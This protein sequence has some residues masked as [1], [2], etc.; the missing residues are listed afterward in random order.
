MFSFK[1]ETNP[2]IISNGQPFPEEIH[3]ILVKFEV[4]PNT[5]EAKKNYWSLGENWWKQIID[6][7][8]HKFG[9]MVFDQGLHKGHVEPGY[10]EGI[11][12]ASKYFVETFDKKFGS[13]I[14]KKTHQLA[15]SHFKVE[16]GN[17]ILCGQEEIG[18]FR[19]AEV[20]CVSKLD[21]N[22]IKIEKIQLREIKNQVNQLS[23]AMEALANAQVDQDT[24][25]FMKILGLA[26]PAMDEIEKKKIELKEILDSAKK[27]LS[28][29]NESCSEDNPAVVLHNLKMKSSKIH[30]QILQIAEKTALKLN[31]HF[32]QIAKRLKLDTPFVTCTVQSSLNC[33]RPKLEI[34]YFQAESALDFGKIAELLISEF[35]D[36][37]ERLQRDIYQKISL[38]SPLEL[39]QEYQK[40][41]LALISNLYAELE[42]VHPWKDGQGRTDLISLN[43]LLCKEG[44]Q[45]CI[46]HDP[47]FSTFNP[48]MLW[49]Q[50][51]TDGLLK[52][53]EIRGHSSLCLPPKTICPIDEMIS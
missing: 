10:L 21:K 1:I 12:K 11:E 33:S 45:P 52:F 29:L 48:P 19:T 38:N 3:N 24:L 49:Q 6:G 18:L 4:I 5:V 42:W 7:K 2:I 35:N 8:A 39:K 14:Y 36:E 30:A 22:R 41:V 9:K 26:T 40:K 15:C 27:L 25:S 50:K 37:L 46:L 53:E 20:T 28:Q 34:K 23:K 47:Y 43:G 31:D 44:L 13:E 17:G 32:K 51:L 16:P